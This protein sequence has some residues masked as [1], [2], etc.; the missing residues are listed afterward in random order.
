MTE[1]QTC[2][3]TALLYFQGDLH[4]AHRSASATDGLSATSYIDYPKYKPFIN[5]DLL[6]SPRKPV[7]PYP[8][9]NSRG[10]AS[11]KLLFYLFPSCL[12]CA[13]KHHKKKICA[14]RRYGLFS[15]LSLPSDVQITC[16]VNPFCFSVWRMPDEKVL[17]LE[18]DAHFSSIEL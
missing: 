12:C 2:W 5:S 15:H 10:N 7:I 3:I 13:S 6:R 4:K 17:L 14:H 18:K 8:E 9:S 1:K 16:F 11:A